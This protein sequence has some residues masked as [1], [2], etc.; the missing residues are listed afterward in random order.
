VVRVREEGSAA[1]RLATGGTAFATFEGVSTRRHQQHRV[2]VSEKLPQKGL[3]HW[4]SRFAARAA[5]AAGSHWAFIVT[6]FLIVTW[7]VSG[8]FF[9]FSDTW[10]LIANTVT[11]LSTALMVFLIQN[12]QNRDARAIHLKLDELLRATPGARNEFMDV[13]EEDLDEIEREKAIVDKDDPAPPRERAHG[14]KLR[15]AHRGNGKT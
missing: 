2:V 10:Q 6:G 9:G 5:N 7:F 15:D 4:F 3:S 1:A 13:E 8:P 14:D 12:T 11:T